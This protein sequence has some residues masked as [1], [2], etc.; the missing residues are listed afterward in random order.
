MQYGIVLVVA[1]L[2][3]AVVNLWISEDPVRTPSSRW[4][5]KMVAGALTLLALSTAVWIY[6]LPAI[7]GASRASGSL[8]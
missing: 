6:L 4:R 2:L 3:A 8:L 5:R 1:L 7:D